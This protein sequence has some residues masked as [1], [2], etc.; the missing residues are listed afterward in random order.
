MYGMHF[1]HLFK[2]WEREPRVR[3]WMTTCRIERQDLKRLRHKVSKER[4]DF[5]KGTNIWIIICGINIHEPRNVT[6]MT[7]IKIRKSRSVFDMILDLWPCVYRC[8]VAMRCVIKSRKCQ[9][10]CWMPMSRTA[11]IMLYDDVV[12]FFW[13]ETRVENKVQ[14]I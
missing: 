4:Q 9:I 1:A 2:M 13:I 6:Q 10:I 3:D 14:D 7:S 11:I 5:W 12:Y 8:M